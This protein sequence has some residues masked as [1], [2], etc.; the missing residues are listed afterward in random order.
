MLVFKDL[1]IALVLLGPSNSVLSIQVWNAW[2][3]GDLNT[4]AAMGV[5]MVL[6][7]GAL[8]MLALF[9]RAKT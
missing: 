5:I 2:G 8:V 1:T 9:D 7:M 6:V 4:A 3:A